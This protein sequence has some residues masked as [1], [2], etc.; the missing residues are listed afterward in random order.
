MKER[1]SIPL[2]KEDR[3][4]KLIKALQCINQHP[5]S[6]EKQ[7]SC[8]L[9]LYPNKTEKSVFRGMI[10]PTLR[11]LGLI[12]GFGEAIRLSGNGK[13]IVEAA[14]RSIEEARRVARVVLLDEDKRTFHFVE[15]LRR[16]PNILKKNF[17]DLKCQEIEGKPRKRVEE[18]I[19]RWLRVLKECGLIELREERI[20]PRKKNYKDAE[21]E[22]N[23][24]PKSRLFRRVLFEQYR[25]F[26]S[27]E[28]AG[29]VDIPLLRQLVAIRYYTDHNMILTESQFDELLRR[30]PF[31]TEDYVVSLGQSMGAEEKLFLYKGNYYRTLSITFFEKG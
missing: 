1:P 7:R 31:V 11:Y 22:L 23:A 28:T 2:L 20:N 17:I 26:P 21:K 25:S 14:K 16:N 10:I 4:S 12:L 29:I 6:R 3:V 19:N 5:Y 8:I 18:R 24:E 15:I 27:Y 9:R 30:L 13:I